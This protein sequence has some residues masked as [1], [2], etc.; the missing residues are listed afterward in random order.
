MSWRDNLRPASFRGVKFFV[1]SDSLQFGRRIQIHE[2]PQ[3]DK[4]FV[5]D[6]GKK[7]RQYQFEAFVIG[8]DYMSGRDALIEA[9]EKPGA[10][11]LIHPKYGCVSVVPSSEGEVNESTDFGGMAKIRLSFIEAGEQIEPGQSLDTLANIES[12]RLTLRE[13]MTSWFAENFSVEGFQDFVSEDAINCVTT[14]QE[15]AGFALDTMTTVREFVSGDLSLLNPKNLLTTLL[16]PSD[17]GSGILSL[18]NKAE[19]IRNLSDFSLSDRANR[20]K[21]EYSES[22]SVDTPSS[23]D[24]LSTPDTAAVENNRQAIEEL[25]H[26]AVTE[27]LIAQYVDEKLPSTT[28]DAIVA[29]ANILTMV[30]DIVFE[31]VIN[32]DTLNALVDYRDAVLLHLLELSPK[33]PK[34][35]TVTTKLDLPAAVIAYQVYGERWYENDLASQIVAR[36]R[37]VHAGFVPAGDVEVVQY[38]DQGK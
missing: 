13:K 8:P 26:I 22:G 29:K 12:K 31:P 30:D 14:L 35:T 6:L 27:Q 34:V 7:A 15:A 33:L 5:E 36:N 2:Y 3:R 32:A 9:C 24:E 25:V 4:P 20:K 21:Y 1:T 38:D 37:V 19:N 11:E 16:A 18:I 10:G 17:L 28:E 23:N